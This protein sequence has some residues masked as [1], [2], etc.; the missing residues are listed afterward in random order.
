MGMEM[1]MSRNGNGKLVH[2]NGRA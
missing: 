1:N 2:R